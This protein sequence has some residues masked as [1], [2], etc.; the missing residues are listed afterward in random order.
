M[1]AMLC[2]DDVGMKIWRWLS[3]ATGIG[4]RTPP[5]LADDPVRKEALAVTA[6]MREEF[7]SQM[8]RLETILRNDA[9][10]NRRP[11]R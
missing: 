11:D 7:L 6:E 5:R 1:I 4:Y 9:R 2:A 3:R 10:N 8:A